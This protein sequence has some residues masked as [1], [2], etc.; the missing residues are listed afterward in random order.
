[1]T[2]RTD[3]SPRRQISSM[4]SVSSSCRGGGA[5]ERRVLLVFRDAIYDEQ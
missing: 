5:A 1:M 2:E 4:T 3:V